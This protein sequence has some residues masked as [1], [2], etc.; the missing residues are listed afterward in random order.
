M[1]LTQD[2]YVPEQ[3]QD[4]V[5]QCPMT[6]EVTSFSEQQHYDS[7]YGK[8]IW[9]RCAKCQSWHLYRSDECEPTASA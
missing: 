9:W 2:L 8:L 1:S 4:I 5:V 7:P 6:K 3:E